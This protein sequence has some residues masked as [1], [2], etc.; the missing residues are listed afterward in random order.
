[1]KR[2]WTLLLPIAILAGCETQGIPGNGIIKSEN[3][4]IGEF[5][6]LYVGGAFEV[7]VSLGGPPNLTL[8]GDEN[9]IPL[10]RT[11]VNGNR[12]KIDTSQKISPTQMIKIALSGR[13]LIAVESAGANNIMIHGIEGKR[14]EADLSGAG[15]IE[16]AGRVEFLEVDLQ[17]AGNVK[18]RS[19][20]AK[21]VDV[22][23]TGASNAEVWASDTLE[24]DITGFGSV[25]YYGDPQD[26]DSNITGAGSIKRRD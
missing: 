16:L 14:F 6:E 8:T 21:E 13:Q 5:M 20:E 10:V 17:G 25:D 7:D 19:L 24:A 15:N 11:R 2:I 1:M 22:S 4:E 26:V 12:L 3:R 23:L 18:A 9:L